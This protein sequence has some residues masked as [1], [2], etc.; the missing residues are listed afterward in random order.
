MSKVYY[1]TFYPLAHSGCL[2]SHYEEHCWFF[3]MYWLVGRTVHYTIDRV[4]ADVTMIGCTRL[5]ILYQ[6]TSSSRAAKEVVRLRWLWSEPVELERGL[7]LYS[8]SR[9]D[10]PLLPSFSFALNFLAL[11]VEDPNA[12]T[13]VVSLRLHHAFGQEARWSIRHWWLPAR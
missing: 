3:D 11:G 13:T 9:L 12:Q 1:H 4:W 7:Y 5:F 6:R 8:L 2:Y 10:S